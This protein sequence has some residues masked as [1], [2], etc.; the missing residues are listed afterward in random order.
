LRW[1]LSKAISA[2]IENPV[3][4]MQI[5]P[6]GSKLHSGGH[7]EPWSVVDLTA[8]ATEQGFFLSFDGTKR[9]PVSA[10]LVFAL[11]SMFG[12]F[13]AFD[14]GRDI[15]GT[16]LM[17]TRRALLEE[18]FGSEWVRYV[19]ARVEQSE[20]LG[21]PLRVRGLP[22]KRAPLAVKSSI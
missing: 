15:D 5:P 19:R 3:M 21:V 2:P 14:G 11:G 9:I 22:R 4:K 10:D 13:D 17:F 1:W 18:C 20:T 7:R 8:E 16:R 12:C 6:S